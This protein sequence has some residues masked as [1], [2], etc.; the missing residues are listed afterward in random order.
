MKKTSC[1]VKLIYFFIS[2]LLCY[3]IL[4]QLFIFHF[5]GDVLNM[6]IY[7]LASEEDQTNLYNILLSPSEED[8]QVIFSC[9]LRRGGPGPKSSPTYE[10]VHFVGYFS[11]FF[12]YVLKF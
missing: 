11:K 5:Q 2:I 9:H 8:K 3:S 12:S 4:Y 1:N 7:E 6:T 10:L